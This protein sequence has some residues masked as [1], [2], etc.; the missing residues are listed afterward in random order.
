MKWVTRERAKVDRVAC[1]WLIRKFIDPKAVFLFV[2]ADQ[3]LEVA[4]REGAHS[5]DAEGAEYGHRDGKCTFETLIEEFRLGDPALNRLALIVHGADIPEELDIAP[6]AAGLLAV[7]EGMTVI[8]PDDYR[9][10]EL[11]F[12]V[13]DALY[14]YCTQK[15]L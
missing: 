15:L 9:K 13:Y 7:A 2:P 6:E 12:P 5:F 8:A 1:P 11:L 3:V 4:R 14:T 10:M